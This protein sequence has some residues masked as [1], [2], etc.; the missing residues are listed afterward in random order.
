M[1]EC[2]IPWKDLLWIFVFYYCLTFTVKKH[3]LKKSVVTAERMP[4]H[5]FLIIM[6]FWKLKYDEN[7]LNFFVAL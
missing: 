2:T 3:T 7:S 5:T 4:G 1:A 6:K